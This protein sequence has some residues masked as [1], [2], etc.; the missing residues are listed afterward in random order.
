MEIASPSP[1]RDGQELILI[2]PSRTVSR[3]GGLTLYIDPDNKHGNISSGRPGLTPPSL[4]SESS[5]TPMVR[6]DNLEGI[7]PEAQIMSLRHLV[8]HHELQRQKIRTSASY[9]NGLRDETFGLC[10]TASSLI[11]RVDRGIADTVHHLKDGDDIIRGLSN[12]FNRPRSVKGPNTNS[13]TAP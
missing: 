13:T 1:Y 9:L 2:P 11:G 4:L 6:F 10:E 7:I 3:A 12:A 5:V 8:S